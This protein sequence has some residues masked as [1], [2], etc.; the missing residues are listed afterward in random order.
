MLGLGEKKTRN[1]KALLDLA[2][3]GLNVLTLG[4]YLQPSA[5]YSPIDRWVTP[6]EFD[7]W[8]VEAHNLGIEVV[9]SG[10]LVRSSYHADE[11]SA[12]YSKH[13]KL[14]RNNLIKFSFGDFPSKIFKYPLNRKGVSRG[15]RLFKN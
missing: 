6:E 8:K 10:P 14:S 1:Q 4:Q 12:R 7:S 5:E 11:Q 13:S 2:Q 3:I 15:K 9:E